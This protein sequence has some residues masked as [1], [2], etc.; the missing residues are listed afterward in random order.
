MDQIIHLCMSHILLQYSAPLLNQSVPGK[1]VI[2]CNYSV[3]AVPGCNGEFLY[4]MNCLFLF[5][6]Y[7][8]FKMYVVSLEVYD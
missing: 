7:K 5:Y 6:V 3:T 2:H 8:L 4:H 1:P